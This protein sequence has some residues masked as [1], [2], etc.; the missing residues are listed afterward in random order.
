M[1]VPP[2]EKSDKS[3]CVPYGNTFTEPGAVAPAN[4]L[5]APELPLRAP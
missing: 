1:L 5:R 4:P 3:L 2:R